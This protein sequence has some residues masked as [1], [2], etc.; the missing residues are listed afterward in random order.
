[1]G[2]SQSRSPGHPVPGNT[3]TSTQPR[4]LRNRNPQLPPQAPPQ[5]RAPRRSAQAQTHPPVNQARQPTQPRRQ[6]AQPPAPRQPNRTTP[7]RAQPRQPQNQT[8]TH[9]Q[10]HSTNYQAPRGSQPPTRPHAAQNPTA[11]ATPNTRALRDIVHSRRLR[12]G[13][14][15]Q[16]SDGKW[17]FCGG[18]YSTNYLFQRPNGQYLDG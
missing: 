15:F 14:T 17:R 1:M 11:T 2:N 4:V 9:P 18:D 6:N 5:T 8:R 7:Q 10:P 3:R 13:D 12:P 16:I